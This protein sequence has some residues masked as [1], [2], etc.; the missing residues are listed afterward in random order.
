MA[1]DIHKGILLDEKFAKALE[2]IEKNSDVL[3]S[4]LKQF[5]DQEHTAVSM[6]TDRLTAAKGTLQ[7]LTSEF[8]K[9]RSMR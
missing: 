7:D 4:L 6:Q 8:M 1:K 5:K 2:A 3:Y 9:I